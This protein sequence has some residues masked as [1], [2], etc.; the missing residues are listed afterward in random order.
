[1]DYLLVLII[2]ILIGWLMTWFWFI[3]RGR[4]RERKNL[5]GAYDK[6]IKEIADKS[7]KAREDKRKSR[8][9]AMRAFV[10][11]ALYGLVI[12]V[13]VVLVANLVGIF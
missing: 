11:S 10:E 7:K 3:I 13:L 4:W 1:M 6:T 2:G 5:R 12:V 8:D 9:V